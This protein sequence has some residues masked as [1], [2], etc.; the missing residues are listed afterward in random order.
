MTDVRLDRIR[1]VYPG[2]VV[3]VDD[4]SMDISHG[5]FVVLLGPSGCGKSTLLQMI[6]GLEPQTGGHIHFGNRCV[7][8]LP[9]NKRDVAMVF[10]SYALYPN[11]SVYKNMAFGLRMRQTPKADAEQRV[12]RAARTLGLEQ[13]LDRRPNQLSGGQRQRVALGR[14]IVRDPQVFLL[15]EP[16]SNVDA[17]LRNDMRIELKALHERLQATF[18]YVTHDQA[19]AM[20]LGDYVAVMD[21]GSLRQYGSPM[22][23]YNYPADLFVAG[24]VG[25]PAMNLIPGELRVSDRVRFDTAVMRY[26]WSAAAFGEGATDGRQVVAGFRPG[27][28]KVHK[29]TG[30]QAPPSG[31]NLNG[32]VKFLEPLGADLLLSVECA[33]QRI[34]VRVDPDFPVEPGETVQIAVGANR[35]HVFDA[36]SGRRIGRGAPADPGGASA[37]TEDDMRHA[38]DPG[39]GREKAGSGLRDRAQAGSRRQQ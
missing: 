19:E 24:F 4:V 5:D 23:I 31:A 14:A 33:G 15:D 20:S 36:G 30:D 37:V 39:P 1:K 18:I 10:Q 34:V 7:D 28:V 29:E 2:G 32:T 12:R 11:M 13:V 6:A 16:L 27:D 26:E 35:M 17:K 8:G 38:T 25:S 21:G 22:E 3:G 9:A